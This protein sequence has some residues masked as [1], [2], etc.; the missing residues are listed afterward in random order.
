MT[1]V[2][3]TKTMEAYVQAKVQSGAYLDAGEVVRAGVRL[4]MERDG[5]SQFYALKAELELAF[6]DVE[7]GKTDNFDPREFEPDAFPA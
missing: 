6:N 2:H 5:A 3:L 1:D 7:A 4:L